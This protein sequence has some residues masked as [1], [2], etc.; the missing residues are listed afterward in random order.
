MRLLQISQQHFE[1]Q[2]ERFKQQQERDSM[3]NTKYNTKQ[4]LNITNQVLA[5][6]LFCNLETHQKYYKI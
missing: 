3:L 6:F 5:F 4:D 2:L 1:T